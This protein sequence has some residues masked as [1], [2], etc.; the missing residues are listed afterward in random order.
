[1]TKESKSAVPATP[2]KSGGTRSGTSGHSEASYATP[3]TSR[4][5]PIT[6]RAGSFDESAAFSDAK[7]D[8]EGY[9]EEKT[10]VAELSEGAVVS[11]DYSTGVRPLARN[12]TEELEEVAGPKPANDS[13][14]EGLTGRTRSKATGK[15]TTRASDTR[16]PING[17]T[18]AANK[19]LGRTL[20]L[21]RTKSSWLPM[22]GPKLVRQAVWM[23]L[24]AELVVPVDSTSTRQVAQDSVLLLRAMGCE[25]Q[26]FPSESSLNDWTAVDAGTA[27]LK[28]KKKLRAAISIEEIA[29]G[30]QAIARQAAGP[31]D[32][33]QYSDRRKPLTCMTPR[34]DDRQERITRETEVWKP[35]PS[36]RQDT[37]RR[38][39][40]CYDLRDDSSDSESEVEEADNLE[41][42]LTVEWA[43]QIRELSRAESKNSTPRFEIAT[44][45]PLVNI[46]PFAV[47]RFKNERSMQWLR[48]FIYEMKGMHTPPN[49]WCMAFELSLQ[50]GALHWYR[51]LPRKTRRQWKLLSDAFIKYYC[52][53]FNQSAK[54]RYYSA[55]RGEKEHMCDYLNRLNGYARNA[56]VQFENGGCE[57]KDH[58]EN[59]LDTC[60]DRGLAE[61]LCNVRVRDIHDLETMIHNIL[62]RKERK[63]SREPTARKSHS[64]ENTRRRD[65]GRTEDTRSS[66][67]RDR[68]RDD[69]RRR[70]E[71]PYRPRITLADALSDFVAALNVN[72]SLRHYKGQSEASRY[73]EEDAEPLYDE[74]HQTNEGQC[75][76]EYPDGGYASDGDYGHIAAAN[77]TERR[78]AAEGSFARSDQRQTKGAGGYSN[79]DK[80]HGPDGRK[81]FGPCAA[82][83]GMPHS[84][85]K[86][87]KQVH[88]AGKCE[89]FAE[90]TTLLRSKIDKRDL[91]PELQSLP[92]NQTGLVSIG[93]PQLTEP[94]VDADY[95]FAFAGEVEWPDD[96]DNK[97]VN[98]K[99]TEEEDSSRYESEDRTADDDDR[100]VATLMAWCA[101]EPGCLNLAARLLPGGRLGWWS[102]QRYDKWKRMGALV[103]GAVNDTRTRILLDTGAN[104]C[105]ARG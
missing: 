28:R 4:M 86:L 91:T 64:R 41:G 46:K 102:A 87:C 82:C 52:S 32:S 101:A 45:L 96:R 1:M 69:V 56:E 11:A 94:A 12:L 14:D 74:E 81:Q 59:F 8:D 57:A 53:K 30:R 65:H 67:R 63:S 31:A 26:M 51:Q 104:C 6:E 35:T 105:P 100:P 44:H 99:I 16:P 10:H 89:A 27:L 88:D 33:S 79:S 38:R 98:K 92:T 2:M 95:M 73:E 75:P 39:T 24:G 77:G 78:L 7:E 49:G 15:R 48:A 13:V 72:G 36:T 60:D 80:N 17:D 23:N 19:V 62:R 25:P 61:R 68:S 3:S 34:S 21:M 22:F 85:H 84:V 42:D 55:T 93:L 43:R 47:L 5:T 90:L 40:H 58:V 9:L 103:M 70:D 83:G 76:E 71:S 18:P 37:G 29:P 97:Q 50:E 54:A 66:Y 20:E